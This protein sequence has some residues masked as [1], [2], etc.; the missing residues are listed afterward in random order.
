MLDQHSFGDWLKR[1]R[2]ALDLTREGLADLV[3]CSAATIRK[4]EAE[5]RRPSA[6]MVDRLADIFNIPPDEQTRFLR[7]A[8]GDWKSGPSET[9]AE[10]PWSVTGNS[11][12]SN[13]PA[14][15]TS[16]IGREKEIAAL[17]EYLRKENIRLITLMGP[18]GIGKTRL[19]IKAARTVLPDFPNGV[20][21]VPLAPLADPAFLG[22]RVAHSLGYVTTKNSS[23]REQLKAGIGDKKLLLVLDNCEHLIEE[24]AS[25]ASDLLSACSHLKVLTTSRE[26]LRIPGEWVYPVPA[27]EVPVLPVPGAISSIDL[28]TAS[29]FPALT[30]F[31]ERARSVRSD[32]AVD[33]DNIRSVASICMQVDGLPLAIELMAARMRFMTPQALL[34][35]L[36]NQFLLSANGMRSPSPRQ[37]TLN[38]AIAWSYRLLSETEQRLFAPLSVF[39]GGFT[40]EAVEAM[41][42]DSFVGTSLSSLLTSLLDKSL[43]QR[44]LDRE[45]PDAM[46]FSMLGM[47]QHFALNR[48]RDMEKEEET[49]KKHLSYFLDLTKR[50]EKEIHGPEQVK[51]LHRLGAMRDN[52]RSALEWAITTGQVEIALQMAN[53]LSWFWNMRSEFS[54]GRLW[55]GKVVEMPEAPRYPRLYSYALAQLALHTWLQ[56]GPEEARPFVQQALSIARAHNDRWNIAWALSI[57][58]LILTDESD[59]IRAQSALEESR[60]LFREVHNDWGYT[61]AVVGLARNAHAQG[62]LAAS[63]ALQEEG[64]VVYRQL[65]DKF[66]ENM[67][68][69][70]IGFIQVRQGNLASGVAALQEVLRIAQQL[71]SKQ[72][73]A[74]ALFHIGDAA[75]AEGN[76]ARAVPLYLAF[77]NVLDSIGAWRQDD[78]AELE[79]NLAT[80]RA[81][82]SES[83]FAEVVEQGRG[84]TME[85]AIAYALEK[86]DG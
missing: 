11:T 34:D 1:K 68:R 51:W 52:L 38:D 71:D 33:A 14:P 2:K 66:S 85:Q 6:Q 22:Q 12:P 24:V 46:L 44:V 19:S 4:L 25:L 58:G 53:D 5:E 55:L 40:Q 54:E 70:F 39:S 18:P 8:R 35:H 10:F 69:C 79:E 17:R 13:L 29:E 67:A 7:F 21:F 77:K 32:F 31:T 45:M 20:F 82:L 73:I 84:M 30:L 26:S 61:Y 74:W 83:E 27:L 9:P 63:L 57:L 59:F 47:I 76:A 78:E 42:V 64:L 72:E 80:C 16:L 81:A 75:Q 62:D 65:G 50:A 56:S 41:F 23:M 36:N 28:E 37:K 60:A 3:G 15:V 86:S 49:R 48:L 43:L